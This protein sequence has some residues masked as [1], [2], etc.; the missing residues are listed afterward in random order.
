MKSWKSEAGPSPEPLVDLLYVA[1]P[2]GYLQWDEADLGGLYRSSPN[3]DV[4]HANLDKIYD[5]IEDKLNPDNATFRS[6]GFHSFCSPYVSTHR[7]G[8]DHLPR[9]EFPSWARELDK[10]FAQRNLE[11]LHNQYLP[12]EDSLAHPWTHMHLLFLPEV[13]R[14]VEDTE[15][16]AG[17]WWGVYEKAIEEA[18]RGASIR[19]GMVSAVGRKAEGGADRGRDLENQHLLR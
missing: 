6:V 2:G 13:I 5:L 18:R 16:S 8:S 3:L 17:P 10:V 19:M 7:P 15:G 1:E 14:L 4:S 9:F 11:V 12:I